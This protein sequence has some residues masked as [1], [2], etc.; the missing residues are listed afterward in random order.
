MCACV[1]VPVRALATG[2]VKGYR[3]LIVLA[4]LLSCCLFFSYESPKQDL[5]FLNRS[6][7]LSSHDFDHFRG[8]ARRTVVHNRE[9]CALYGFMHAPVAAARARTHNTSSRPICQPSKEFGPIVVRLHH[10]IENDCFSFVHRKSFRFA[11][12]RSTLRTISTLS[13]QFQLFRRCATR[14][15]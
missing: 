9:R 6:F 1:L 14:L 13:P 5:P 10:T 3:N 4:S 2:C 11:A 15:R 7:A 12:V 8:Y